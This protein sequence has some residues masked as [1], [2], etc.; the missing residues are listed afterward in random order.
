MYIYMHRNI[1]ILFER[2]TYFIKIYTI[3]KNLSLSLQRVVQKHFNIASLQLLLIIVTIDSVSIQNLRC[4]KMQ[5]WKMERCR[6]KL[7]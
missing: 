2:S 4:L 5:L 1:I 3:I 6:E 7:S